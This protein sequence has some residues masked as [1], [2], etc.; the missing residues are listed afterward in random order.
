MAARPGYFCRL[1][2]IFLVPLEP[3]YE[4]GLGWI[5]WAR[6]DQT[7][8]ERRRR[9]SKASK[10]SC[11]RT[12]QEARNNQGSEFLNNKDGEKKRLGSNRNEGTKEEEGCVKCGVK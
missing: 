11:S 3:S 10:L 9:R 1:S 6:L 5:G 4:L 7:G 8:A 2:W 12:K